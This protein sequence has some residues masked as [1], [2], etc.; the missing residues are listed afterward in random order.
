[1]WNIFKHT[2]DD[3]ICD[4]LYLYRLAREAA[5]LHHDSIKKGIE[6]NRRERGLI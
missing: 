2:Y 1:M 6:K 4:G 3:E 5:D